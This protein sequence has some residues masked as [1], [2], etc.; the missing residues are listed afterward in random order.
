MSRLFEVERIDDGGASKYGGWEAII[1]RPS[2]KAV[3]SG[4][5][6]LEKAVLKMA[7]HA[8]RDYMWRSCGQMAGTSYVIDAGGLEPTARS[9]IEKVL[10]K[11]SDGYE[12]AFLPKEGSKSR[13]YNLEDTEGWRRLFYKQISVAA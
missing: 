1:Y 4:E 12:K 5:E 3:S 2:Q 6:T 9:T 10:S 11:I 7:K 8:F 13:D